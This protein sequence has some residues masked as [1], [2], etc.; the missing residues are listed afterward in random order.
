M[1]MRG[2]KTQ[3]SVTSTETFRGWENLSSQERERMMAQ[4]D[5]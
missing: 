5:G 3:H 2:V 1:M 4:L